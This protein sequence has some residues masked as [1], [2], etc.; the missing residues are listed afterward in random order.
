M[1][2]AQALAESAYTLK[3]GLAASERDPLTWWRFGVP[4]LRM[5][6]GMFSGPE[7]ITEL[8]LRACNKGG[9]T[10]SKA[11]F[12]MACLQKRQTLDGVPI[13]QWRGPIEALQLVLDYPQQLLSV[14][15]AYLKAL[16]RWPAEVRRNGEYLSSIRVM[17][18]GG[19][20]NDPTEWSVVHFLS[21]KNVD[22][23]KG[24][25][26]DL[27]DFDEPPKMEFLE[28]L[29]KAAHA[30]RRMVRIIGETPLKRRE[31]APLRADYGDCPRSSIKRVDRYRAE[32]RWS[33]H[34]VS[35]WV[36][37]RAEKDELLSDWRRGAL[38]N[39]REHGDY[40]NAE[41]KCPFDAE[42][43]VRM[44]AECREP[45]LVTWRVSRETLDGAP[46][47]IRVPVEVYSPP[48]AGKTYY[49]DIDPA[50]GVDDGAHNPA[51]LHVSEHGS[52]DLVAR[53]N[54][55][56]AP[57]SLGVLGAA[58]ARQY[59]NAAADIEMRDHWGV[60]V[61]RGFN[62]SHYGNLAHETR[63]LR[64][65]EFAKEVGFD[66]NEESRAA[67]IG[68]IQ[69]WIDAY[70]IGA[71]YAKCPSRAVIECLLD[72]ELDDRGKIVAGPGI[73]HGEDMVLWGQKLRLAVR[74]TSRETPE[75]VEP[76]DFSRAY[77]RKM[78]AQLTGE[79]DEE[80]VQ[81]PPRRP[82]IPR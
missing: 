81:P 77:E 42:T 37:S 10:L 5:A 78:F 54:G 51:A 18:V 15:P 76:L 56:L 59:N 70:R 50:S 82:R 64:P 72:T 21:Q 66:A 12:V 8:H 80:E 60:N 17:P 24:A 39:A 46:T 23:G 14:K 49:L 61:L 58:L 2:A 3:H 63:E 20:P 35:D 45:E 6:F 73:A 36:L 75:L 34:E 71:P 44:L 30:G 19:N 41:G 38:P 28:E 48:E 27:V 62:A 52:G 11:A 79:V 65:G 43:L 13:P 29:R 57:Y 69:E 67:W 7:P 33:L 55:Y 68:C 26:A 22:T 9:K 53:W 25:R 74:R 16:G 32:C 47:V 4:R 1:D 31:W 40:E